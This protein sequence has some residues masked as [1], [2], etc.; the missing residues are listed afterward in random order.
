MPGRV[1]GSEVSW[2]GSVR[3]GAIRSK[4][5]LKESLVVGLSV[6]GQAVEDRD[7]LRDKPSHEMISSGLAFSYCSAELCI[8][9]R[10]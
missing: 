2:R 7:Q 6:K 8:K 3:L 5:D 1:S 10:S 9:D 4:P